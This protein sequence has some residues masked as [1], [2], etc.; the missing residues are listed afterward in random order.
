MDEQTGK[1]VVERVNTAYP[2]LLSYNTH[3]A[4]GEFLQRFCLEP[5]AKA[6]RIGLLSKS[7]AE[8]GYLFPNGQKCSHDAIAWPNGERCDIINSAGGHPAA[9]GP[10]WQ[11]IP[12]YLP[13][14]TLNWRPNNVYVDISGWPLYDSGTPHDAGPTGVCEVGFGWFCMMTA[15]AEWPDEAKPNMDWI[16]RECNPSFFRVM[17]CVEGESHATGGDPDVW[18]E[19][20]VSIKKDWENRYRKMLEWLKSLGRQAHCTIYG[21]RNQTPTE[22]DRNRFH[23]RIIAASDGLWDVI[24]SVECANEYKVNKWT[25]EEVRAMGRDMRKK[26][27]AGFR[28]SLSSPDA[29]HAGS[30]DMSNE[31]MEASFEELYGGDD[32]A[33]ANEITI[34]TMRD[35][36]KWSD[37]FSY[38]FCM[39]DMPKINNEPPG[40][41]SSAGGMY[42]T[43]ADVEKDLKNTQGAGWAA[44]VAHSEWC[45]WNGHLPSVYYNGWRE[46]K[47]CSKQPN[48]PEIAPVLC[49]ASTAAPPDKG[50]P[51]RHDQLLS[52]KQLK[53]GEQ[54]VSGGK[55]CQALY[56][57]D[58]NFVIYTTDGTPKWASQTAGTTPGAVQMNVDGNLVIYDPSGT[59]L[60]ASQT[61]GNPGAMLQLNDDQVLVIY[62][63]P[64]G[65]KAGTP[66]W[67]SRL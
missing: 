44:Y 6:E 2:W 41:G 15:L 24:R 23:D 32:H 42:T 40:P 10:A 60:W 47:E 45:V 7:E 27:P 64:T 57:H 56:D 50:P 22:S 51:P 54:L 4:C 61:A 55:T 17:L 8:N 39:P 48:M 18:T 62:C 29:A 12:E 59:P 1:K 38:N 66:L 35:G 46:I 30:G 5:E 13:D 11:P 63:D 21:G 31:V 26:L 3:A 52:G 19:A 16:L 36:G 25:T 67:S 37:P 58:G 20:G 65:D 34:H 43:A 53:P 49:A 33:G 28:L 14:G 9:G